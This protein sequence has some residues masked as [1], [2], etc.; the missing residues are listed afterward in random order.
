M[1]EEARFTFG[2]DRVSQV[3]DPCGERSSAGGIDDSWKDSFGRPIVSI[4][5]LFVNRPCAHAQWMDEEEGE[6]DELL[7]LSKEEEEEVKERRKW[8]D[9]KRNRTRRKE[10]IQRSGRRGTR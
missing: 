6:S 3:K 2:G 9:V 10:N 1:R 4:I 5:R 8:L 7:F